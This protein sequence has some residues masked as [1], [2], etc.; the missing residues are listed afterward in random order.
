MVPLVKPWGK[1]HICVELTDPND[2]VEREPLILLAVDETL[3][4]LEGATVWQVPLHKD[5]MLLTTLITPE[6][7][8]YIKRLPFGIAPEDLWG[9]WR[10][11]WS[12]LPHWWCPCARKRPCKTQRQT[13]VLNRADT[14]WRGGT[15]TEW[16][17]PVSHDVNQVSQACH[18]CTKFQV[19]IKSEQYRTC[20]N[21]RMWQ[22]SIALWAW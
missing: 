7:R 21:Q 22:M 8:Y 1:M 17:V 14:I 3:A 13:A 12:T 11:G 18:H 6:G 9:P 2:S 20:R 15:Y 16:Q 5:S 10:N 4:R 19:L